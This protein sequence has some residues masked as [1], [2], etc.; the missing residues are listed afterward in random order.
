MAVTTAKERVDEQAGAERRRTWL[1]KVR[2]EVALLL[3]GLLP[4]L[5]IYGF[6]WRRGYF[7]DDPF[8]DALSLRELVDATLSIRARPLGTVL[9]SITYLIG[10][11][12]G[13][14]L[15]ALI[16][17]LTATLAALLVRRTCG[18][19]YAPVITA[20]LVIYPLLDWES[21]L[22]WYA[23]IQY[24]AGAAFGLAAGHSF[25]STLRATNRRSSLLSGIGTVALLAGGL[26]CTEVAVNFVVLIPG[27]T[28]VEAARLRCIG[29]KARNR[30]GAVMVGAAGALTVVGAVIYLPKSEFT[31][32][33]GELLINPF[34]ALNRIVDVW[35]PAL[36]NTAFSASRAEIHREAFSLGLAN[37]KSPAVASV[38][39]IAILIGFVA[40]RLV[41][42]TPVG[43]FR[44]S[45]R[46][47]A[48]VLAVVG[49]TLFVSS[50]L[51]PAALLSGQFPVTRLLFTPWIGFV[52]AVGA[53][54]AWLEAGASPRPLKVVV[55]LV[56]VALLP[57][58]LTLDGYG[59]LFRLRHARNVEQLNGWLTLLAAVEPLPPGTHIVSLYGG[60]RLLGRP[61]AVDGSLAGITETPW[62]LARLV[63]EARGEV[64]P[65][66][67]GHPFGPLCIE[68][69][70]DPSRVRVT[71]GFNDEVVPVGSLLAAEVH[72]DRLVVVDEVVFGSTSVQLPLAERVDGSVERL[73]M[74][75][76][77][78]VACRAFGSSVTP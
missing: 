62:A 33:R 2:P 55:V 5:V 26:A 52:L 39:L 27:L 32:A 11:A 48:A 72:D 25:L 71:S 58:A 16:L 43:P 29:R 44:P 20:L 45:A 31:S 18:G 23:A 22:Y 69:T 66:I 77:E 37:L 54:V 64:I 50:L 6:H 41:M 30:S 15:A 13:R 56:T 61:S 40:L 34:D 70:E 4:A 7:L 21:A 9:V 28:V 53:L 51:F 3:A 10:E 78:K 8:M 12:S 73:R 46:R 65:A 38:F 36:G 19:R 68:R 57:L 67:G 76:N 63:F 60:D 47:G 75:G 35:I 14:V 24:P 1:D 59:E 49:L 17:A 42:H 74:V